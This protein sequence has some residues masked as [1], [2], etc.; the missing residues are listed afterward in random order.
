VD[1]YYFA[2]YYGLRGVYCM[3]WHVDM[4]IAVRLV[5]GTKVEI[6]EKE[7][8]GSLDVLEAKYPYKE[9]T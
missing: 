9:I 2:Y 5:E 7:F 3:K 4:P 6:T 1:K 8:H